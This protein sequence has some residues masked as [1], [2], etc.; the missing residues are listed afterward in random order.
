MYMDLEL[1]RILQ[2]RKYNN[3]FCLGKYMRRWFLNQNVSFSDSMLHKDAVGNIGLTVKNMA[4][5][6]EQTYLIHLACE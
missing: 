5:H 3:Y 1:Q 6:N 4:K 2:P